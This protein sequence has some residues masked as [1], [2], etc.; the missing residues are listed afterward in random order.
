M[1][2]EDAGVA[3]SASIVKTSIKHE[4]I[5]HYLIANPTASMGEV[6]EKFNL[7]RSWLSVVVNSE[8]FQEARRNMTEQV[9][10]DTVLPLREKMIA[11][12]DKALDRLS[13]LTPME[14]DLDKV[15]K[16]AES[17][18]AAC[19]FSSRQS[20]T[21]NGPVTQ[22]NTQINYNGNASPEVLQRARDRIGQATPA[23]RL[24]NGL[25][26]PGAGGE[27]DTDGRQPA[28]STSLE[29]SGS[30]G[31]GDPDN[32]PLRGSPGVHQSDFCIEGGR[33]GDAPG[34]AE[35]T[36]FDIP[37]RGAAGDS[38]SGESGEG[39]AS[40]DSGSSGSS[41]QH[42]RAGLYRGRRIAPLSELPGGRVEVRVYETD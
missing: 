31:T 17:T 2:K 15:R 40:G 37:E 3:E 23:R 9:Y 12:A 19:G 27:I 4:A 1:E 7:S 29:N 33:G 18:L 36:D 11:V 25:E 8:A 34:D 6:A 38:G 13:L 39:A 32:F 22:F 5:L 21:P 20:P 14:T 35:A 30:M 42:P 26:P 28:L 16:T 24:P 10:T 41:S